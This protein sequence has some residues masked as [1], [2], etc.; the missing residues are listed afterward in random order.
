[1]KA[2]TILFILAVTS[3]FALQESPAQLFDNLRVF[4]DRVNVGD[5]EV[6]T[7]DGREGPKG[8][9]TADFNG[10]GKPDLAISNLDGTVTLLLGEGG[11]QFEEPQHLSTGARTLRGII[12]TDLNGDTLPDI[13][14]AAPY[15]GHVHLFL[16]ASGGNFTSVDPLEIWNGVRNLTAGDFD[17]DGI[18]DLAVAGPPLGLRQLRGLG[19]GTF[20]AIGDFPQLAPYDWGPFPKPVYSLAPLPSQSGEGDA[21]L[22]THAHSDR[23]WLLDAPAEAQGPSPEDPLYPGLYQSVPTD[24]PASPLVI[25]EFMAIN[26]QTLPDADGDY[27]DWVEIYNRSEEVVSLAGWKLT[28]DARLLD[29]WSFP[30]QT[31]QP[32]QFLVIFASNKDRPDAQGNTHSNFKLSG[33][34]EWIA[35][36][37][38][39]GRLAH[40][41]PGNQVHVRV[42]NPRRAS[43]LLITQAFFG[44]NRLLDEDG[45]YVD[46]I[47]ITNQ[48]T[49]PTRAKFQGLTASPD[50]RVDH[51]RLPDA[52][53]QPGESR[54]VFL[55]GKDRSD[56]NGAWHANFAVEN[57]YL[58]LTNLFN[59]PVQD[60]YTWQVERFDRQVADVSFG[61]GA[62]RINGYFDRPTPGHPNGFSQSFES[63]HPGFIT[64]IA[65][66]PTEDPN[67]PLRVEISFSRPSRAQGAQLNYGYGR[68]DRYVTLTRDSED[69]FAAL[70][71]A[72]R[73]QDRGLELEWEIYAWGV[74]GQQILQGE[75][76]LGVNQPN[77]LTIIDTIQTQP[78]R[79]I[80]VG[81]VLS[82]VSEG[83]LDLITVNRD[84]GRLQIHRGT[85]RPNRF[86]DLSSINLDVP[87][88][89]RSVSIVDLDRDGWNDLIVALRNFDRVVTF[90]NNS[91]TFTLESEIP[92]G[93]SPRELAIADFSGDGQPDAAVI[94]RISS[95]VSILTTFAGRAAIGTLDQVYPT[96]AEVVQLLAKDMNGDGLDDVIQLHRSSNDATVRYAKPGGKLEDPVYISLGERPSGSTA[97]DVNNDGYVDLITANLG[98]G[99]GDGSISIRLGQADGSYAPEQR[100]SPPETQR[101]GL[102][103][104][105]AADF[106]GDQRVDIAAGYFDCRVAFYRGNG[107]GTFTFTRTDRFTYESRVMTTGDFDKDG[108]IDLAGAGYAGDVVVFENEGDLLTTEKTKRFDYDS[109]SQGKFGTKEITARDVNN[110]G[111]LDLVVGSGSGV[112]LYFGSEGMAFDL[113]QSTLAGVDYPASGLA[114]GDYDGNGTQDI[115]MS[116]RILSCIALLTQGENGK[117]QRALEVDVPSGGF[118][119]SGDLDGDGLAD[120]VGSGDVLWTALSSRRASTKVASGETTKREKLP[121][122][123]INEILARNNDLPVDAGGGKKSDWVELYHGGQE[124]IALGGY[125]LEM[126]FRNEELGETFAR[127]YAFPAEAKLDPG[128]FQL[129]FFSGSKRSLYH[130]GFKL[131]SK[132]AE[133]CL[134][135]ANGDEIDRIA[136]PDQESNVS[137][138]R[139]EDGLT[140]LTFNPIPSPGRPNRDNGAVPPDLKFDGGFDSQLK[141]FEP[142]R[143]TVKG[144]DD[145]GIVSVNLVYR[146][147][148]APDEPAA[149]VILYDD[150]QHQDGAMTDGVFSG[151]LEP[152]L[153]DGAEILYYLEAEDLSGRT[154][155]IPDDAS[156]TMSDDNAG[157]AASAFSLGVFA[158]TGLQ[159]SEVVSDNETGLQDE[160]GGTPDYIEIRNTSNQ[161]IAM[162]DF[163]LAKDFFAGPTEALAFPDDLMLEPGQYLT[164]FAD[165]NPNQGD[166]HAPFRL[167]RKGDEFFLLRKGQF[168]TSAIMDAVDLPEL[169]DDQAYARLGDTWVI[170]APTPLAGNLLEPLLLKEEGNSVRYWFATETGKSYEVQFSSTLESGDWEV[171]A[172]TLGN[173]RE[174]SV[175]HAADAQGFFRLRIE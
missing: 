119:A 89:P 137:Y 41:F 175:S 31:L 30:N 129:V 125:K 55:S 101:G 45:D 66:N 123:V 10:D 132:G 164:V 26:T 62:D 64:N 35:L 47:E 107:D 153:P 19:D 58:A 102:F 6:E 160:F 12:A 142:I 90:K 73:L 113:I 149:R 72:H 4:Q 151:L 99:T 155:T 156:F 83:R 52:E 18:T 80:A 140:A 120:L 14:T 100:F 17:A 53:L 144:E 34:G 122:L 36:V 88:G 94:N 116:C 79:A 131:P 78:A 68:L 51:W 139:F 23:S 71:P 49:V 110:D 158:N 138:G 2:L 48:A 61:Y 16:N 141:P 105:V 42:E 115:A 108:D 67:R 75:D 37:N 163:T 121:R 3:L 1:M 25:T 24:W 124:T 167:N 76:L 127:T 126:S 50:I 112:M 109:P 92:S 148:D 82:P 130:T 77:A 174:S 20:E 106:D 33:S 173:G 172:D 152:G 63:L 8:A 114:L 117:Y 95:D 161:A 9:A 29:K 44:E 147:L 28:D 85:N 40:G 56:P 103:A 86:E 15:E 5:P 154:V 27:S 60:V 145:I 168:G 11:D 65:F 133:L 87:G 143:F 93:V 98:R 169:G 162:K 39:E 70:I 43:R 159:I 69:H 170:T 13:A 74:N 157:T 21:L 104:I 166:L 81:S 96:G 135:D 146:R 54:L 150:G 118:L 134:R 7:A 57:N 38:P 128:G 97:Q 171:M 84:A 46:A 111:D 59:V 91:G 136:Y 165:N 32:G 22:V